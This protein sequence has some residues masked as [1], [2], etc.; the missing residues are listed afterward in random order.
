MLVSWPEHCLIGSWGHNVHA[1]VKKALDRWA[2][3]KLELVDFVT[4]GSNPLTEHYSAVQAEVPDPNDPST[5]LNGRLIK[6]LSEADMVAIAGE[7]LSHC[8]ANTVRDI[9]KNFGED[10]IKKLVVLTDCT[11]SV[12]GFEDLGARFPWRRSRRVA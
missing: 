9:A 6:T 8:V 10:N 5:M 4:K 3:S 1:A 12:A 11:S 2:R 7:A